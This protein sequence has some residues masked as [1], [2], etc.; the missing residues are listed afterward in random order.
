MPLLRNSFVSRHVPVRSYGTLACK[1]D[2]VGRK[3]EGD[4]SG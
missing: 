2:N 1:K 4:L 3:M